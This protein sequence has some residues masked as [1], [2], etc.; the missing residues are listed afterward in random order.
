MTTQSIKSIVSVSGL[1]E[2][3]NQE[4]YQGLA[5]FLEEATKWD[6]EARSI[7]VTDES[8]ATEMKRARELR[9]ILKKTRVAAEKKTAEL[10]A[11]ANIYV[12]TVNGAAKLIE[13]TLSPI[14]DYLQ[15]QEDF[16]KRAQ[17]ARVQALLVARQE[18]L[19]GVKEFVPGLT[20]GS[21]GNASEEDYRLIKHSAIAA[22]DK[23]LA[24]ELEAKRLAEQEASKSMPTQAFIATTP[25][26]P[27]PVL[28]G[29]VF[30]VKPTEQVVAPASTE[31]FWER[32]ASGTPSFEESTP[33]IQ[34]NPDL[35]LLDS[36]LQDVIRLKSIFA[37]YP[38]Q[39]QNSKDLMN[40]VCILLGRLETFTNDGIQKIK[41]AK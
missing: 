8:Q 28:T 29:S 24:D 26:E 11:N 16:A 2:V 14:E 30:D 1:P 38:L 41:E 34:T 18:E 9:L 21:L 20:W 31:S 4:I 40:S 37:K 22:M 3:L 15:E 12:K 6:Q 17:E 32:V 33:Q 36:V 25:P 35:R 19:S 5:P 39:N 10:K 13:S 27:K 7:V 23:K